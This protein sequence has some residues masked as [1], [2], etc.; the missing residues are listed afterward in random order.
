MSYPMVQDINQVLYG[1]EMSS[2][3]SILSAVLTDFVNTRSV[4]DTLSRFQLMFLIAALLN[5]KEDEFY[6]VVG[7][8]NAIVFKKET[9]VSSADFV[10]AIKKSQEKTTTE[11]VH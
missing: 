11:T 1:N 9:G 8:A 3:L 10:K 5:W 4:D 7:Y 2:E 6:D